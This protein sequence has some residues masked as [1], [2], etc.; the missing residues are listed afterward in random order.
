LQ[1][2]GGADAEALSDEVIQ[3]NASQKLAKVC[4]IEQLIERC[5]SEN[6]PPFLSG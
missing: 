4:A 5:R 3:G 6:Q 1:G 2:N